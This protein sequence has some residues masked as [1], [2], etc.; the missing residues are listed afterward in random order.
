MTSKSVT[1]FSK[2][3]YEDIL[4]SDGTMALL[5]KKDTVFSKNTHALVYK[6]GSV[7][8]DSIK[9]QATVTITYT[10]LKG[11]KK[12]ISAK[13]NW[14][15]VTYAITAGNPPT[16]D[17]DPKGGLYTKLLIQSSNADI[18]TSA[19]GEVDGTY[20]GPDYSEI[21]S[22]YLDTDENGETWADNSGNGKS[23]ATAEYGVYSIPSGGKVT[24]TVKLKIKVRYIAKTEGSTLAKYL[25][26]TNSMDTS[27][28]KVKYTISAK[29]SSQT[30]RHTVTLEG[31]GSSFSAFT[32]ISLSSLA[33]YS[34]YSS[35]Y[36]ALVNGTDKWIRDTGFTLADDTGATV[37]YKATVSIQAPSTK[38]SG[39]TVTIKLRSNYA[40]VKYKAGHS[41]Y[42]RYTFPTGIVD[43]SVN[44]V[45][46]AELKEGTLT[47]D[48][49]TTYET[50]INL[51]TINV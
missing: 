21:K 19:K 35:D 3:Q 39:S 7:V 24:D 51:I 1:K 9:Y 23:A 47:H 50:T 15:S 14:A 4:E 28:L 38:S 12:K 27:Q 22:S 49:K 6:K 2:E 30:A 34:V 48:D 36:K 13:S 43:S 46:Y 45:A 8:S 40:T 18:T 41:D 44:T 16:G 37:K 33:K 17:T 32:S 42:Q 10:D 29:K 31:T 11:N 25:K 26:E 5:D 20:M